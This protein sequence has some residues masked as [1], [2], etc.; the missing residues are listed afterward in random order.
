MIEWD[1]NRRTLRVEYVVPRVGMVQFHSPIQNIGHDRGEETVEQIDLDDRM[2][3]L[4]L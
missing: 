2:G 4:K 1:A 3:G